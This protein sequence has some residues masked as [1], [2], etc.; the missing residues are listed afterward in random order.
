MSQYAYCQTKSSPIKYK[1]GENG[2]ELI[3]KDNFETI[4]VSTFK[5]KLSI[6]DE[7][8]EKIYAFYKQNKNKKKAI[9][10]IDGSKAKITGIYTVKKNG[11]LVAVDFKYEKI[12]WE[13]GLVEES[14]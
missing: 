10:S 5:S 11:K 3:A 7:I 12:E 14:E 6:K 9:L 8:A 1:Y 13:N 2:I 4:V